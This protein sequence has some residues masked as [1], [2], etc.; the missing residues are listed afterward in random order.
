M[1]VAPSPSEWLLLRLLEE[2]LLLGGCGLPLAPPSTSSSSLEFSNTSQ[3]EESLGTIAMAPVA[4][5]WRTRNHVH[6]H[7]SHTLLFIRSLPPNI[8]GRIRHTFSYPTVHRWLW[9]QQSWRRFEL[10]DV[11]R[12]V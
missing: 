11:I 2:L 12:K 7:V 8:D 5:A 10:K 6:E 9:Q 1:I 4:M 3:S